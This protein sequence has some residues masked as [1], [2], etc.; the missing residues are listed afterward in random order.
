MRQLVRSLR[1][2]VEERFQIKEKLAQFSQPFRFMNGLWVNASYIHRA[3]ELHDE[4]AFIDPA[5]LWNGTVSVTKVSFAQ[6]RI[7]TAIARA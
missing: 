2:V 3:S 6:S 7:P 1:T 4:P 5:E